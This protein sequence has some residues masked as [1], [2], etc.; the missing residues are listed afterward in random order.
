MNL[1]RTT[2]VGEL[3]FERTKQMLKQAVEAADTKLFCEIIWI[4]GK[5]RVPSDSN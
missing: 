4:C 5:H 3:D 2:P 1:L